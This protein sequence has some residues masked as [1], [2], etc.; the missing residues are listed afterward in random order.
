MA[1][2]HSPLTF[3]EGALGDL[4]GEKTRQAVSRAESAEQG[5]TL[6]LMAPEFQRR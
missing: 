3:V 4:A 5:F 1:R 2:N 6:A